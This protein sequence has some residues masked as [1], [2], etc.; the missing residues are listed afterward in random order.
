M[1]GHGK[2][3]PATQTFQVAGGRDRRTC[4]FSDGVIAEP[5][6]GKASPYG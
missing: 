4:S 1:A 5:S 2:G 6:R 3:D